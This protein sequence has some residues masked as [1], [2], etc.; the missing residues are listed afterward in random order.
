M[1]ASRLLVWCGLVA[2]SAYA[3]P[4]VPFY[5]RA[6]GYVGDGNFAMLTSSSSTLTSPDY[7][8]RNPF[9]WGGVT[10]DK[11]Y[12]C[13]A[14]SNI[15]MVVM[16]DE[17]PFIGRSLQIGVADDYSVNANRGALYAYFR[18]PANAF[19]IDGDLI[20]VNAR[21]LFKYYH[22]SVIRAKKISVWTPKGKPTTFENVSTSTTRFGAVCLDAPIEGSDAVGMTVTNAKDY[23]FGVKLMGDM[24]NYF[25]DLTVTPT[26]LAGGTWTRTTLYVTNTTVGGA[27]CLNAGARLSPL[28]PGE[29]FSVNALQVLGDQTEIALPLD[30]VSHTSTGIRVVQPV[31]RPPEGG[32]IRVSLSCA[33]EPTEEVVDVPILTVPVGSELD[34]DDFTFVRSEPDGV[35]CSLRLVMRPDAG[36][37]TKTLYA[38]CDACVK[39]ILTD[40]D[41]R[42]SE[43][44]S[45][46]TNLTSEGV[47]PNWS[48]GRAV[49]DR[50]DY[51]V[52]GVKGGVMILRTYDEKPCAAGNVPS[53]DYV[54]PGSSLTLGAFSELVI[55]GHSFECADI[56]FNGTVNLYSSLYGPTELRG[57]ISV[58]AGASITSLLY[59]QST[60][61]I[62]GQVSGSGA[63]NLTGHSG[64]NTAN[65]SAT[66]YFSNVNTGF[67]GSVSISIR[68]GTRDG[69]AARLTPQFD[70]ELKKFATLCVNDGRALGGPTEPA[71]PKAVTI[72]N[73]CRLALRDAKSVV[74]DEPT[75]GFFIRWVGRF[76]TEAADETLTVNSPL[77]VYGT[78]HKEGDG[79]LVLGNPQPTFGATAV[80]TVPDADATNRM[81][82]VDGGNVRIASARALNGLD[83]VCANNGS[84]ILLDADTAD[85]ELLN[86]GLI[87]ILTPGMPFAVSDGATKVRFAV[88]AKAV[89]VWDSK[90]VALCTVRRTQKESVAGVLAAARVANA[91]KVAIRSIEPVDTVVDGVDCVTFMATVTP[92]AG[93]MLIFR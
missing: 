70:P 16:N 18:E 71:N 87:D 86:R 36:G 58:A 21:I 32:K 23:D 79:L 45:A 91:G 7:G 26:A 78:L 82:V 51:V 38:L 52:Q 37:E 15:N 22:D 29:G 10:L 5:S 89:P 50:A 25:G 44:S 59:S 19:A 88:T 41:D 1:K 69:D 84:R 76:F 60:L 6:G 64:Y 67:T 17:C 61:Q 62:A 92:N 66:F 27:I 43:Q 81:F 49:H 24:S 54:F 31:A 85:D 30:P 48:D 74:F 2:G 65:P 4:T 12:D 8:Y 75:R 68:A 55:M 83:I 9:C 80:G 90:Q 13:L 34:E 33:G 28:V 72:E 42:V 47:S 73:M 93:L 53:L 14:A 63:F 56:R 46:L 39:M 20:L 11:S 35:S 77:A 40:K 57:G 3:V